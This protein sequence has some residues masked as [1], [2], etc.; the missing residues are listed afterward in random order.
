MKKTL[1][2]VTLIGLSL[3]ACSKQHRE[4][5]QGVINY[6]DCIAQGG[7]MEYPDHDTNHPACVVRRP[8]DSVLR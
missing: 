3:Y 5:V 1:A 7:I 8:P 2:I 6:Q 4:Y